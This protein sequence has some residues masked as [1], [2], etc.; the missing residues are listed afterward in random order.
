MNISLTLPC[1]TCRYLTML[2]SM[3]WGTYVMFAFFVLCN[4]IYAV[5]FLPETRGRHVE[6]MEAVWA[7]HWFWG[8]VCYPDQNERRVSHAILG[9]PPCVHHPVQ[10]SLSCY[11]LH[12]CWLPKSRLR[13]LP[14]YYNTAFPLKQES[15]SCLLWASACAHACS[16]SASCS[17]HSSAQT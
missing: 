10:F 7:A 6:D 13:I 14:C 11:S 3:R 1:T 4:I 9:C 8:K 12:C 2:C 17:Y 5:F 15:A 16:N